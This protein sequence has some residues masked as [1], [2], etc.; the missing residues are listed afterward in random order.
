MA[1]VTVKDFGIGIEEKELTQ[2]F[3]R[4]YRIS[5]EKA[6]TYAGFGIGLFLSNEIIERHNGKIFVKSEIGKG[7]EFTFTIPLNHKL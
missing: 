5:G 4:F 3:K 2:I 1:A 6:D 7:S